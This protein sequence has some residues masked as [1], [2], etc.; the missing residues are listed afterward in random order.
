MKYVYSNATSSG[1]PLGGIGAGSVE[2]RADGLLHDWLIF[3]NGVW[4]TV[5]NRRK[6]YPLDEKSFLLAIRV[7]D[8]REVYVRQLQS[9]GYILG[10]D[11]YKAPWLKPVKLI[12]FYGEPPLARLRYIDDLPV[13]VE[14]EFFS[15]FI[16]GDLKD[17]SMPAVIVKLRVRNKSDRALDV[18]LLALLRSP[19]GKSAIRFKDGILVIEGRG[20][21]IDSPLRDGSMALAVISENV[22]ATAVRAPGY[23]ERGFQ[24]YDNAVEILR[25]WID[26][27]STGA[28]RGPP[29]REGDHLWATASTLFKLAPGGNR[30]TFFVLT[31]FFPNHVDQFGDRL[32]H[33]YEN[34]FNDAEAVAKYVVKNLGRL[35]SET[36]KLHDALYDVK[37][38]ETWVADLV[39]SQLANLVKISWLT[40]DGRFALWEG[41]GDKYYGGPERNAFNTTDVITYAM[42][43]LVSLFPELAAKYLIQHA[44]FSLRRGTPEWVLYAIS[45]PENRREFEK[46][47]ARDPSLA[48]DWQKLLATV[49][50]IVE[51]TGKDPAGRIA[52]YLD[53][54]IKGVDGYH[55]VDL[56]PKYVLMAYITAKW[57]GNLNLLQNLWDVVEGAVESVAKS[58]SVEGLPYHTT[59]SGFEWYRAVRLLF[60]GSAT[61][62]A[63]AA[64]H[65][66]GQNVLPIGFQTFDTWAF[67]GV[68]SYVLALWAAA[69]RAAIDGA[70]RLGK[71]ADRYIELLKRAEEGL[72]VLW[73]G[74]YF[75]LWWDPVTNERDRAS[76]AAQLFGQLLAH[77]ADLGYI[78]DRER[79][80]SS[81]KAVVKYNLA[82]D[83]G[84]INGVY[85]GGDRPSFAGPLTYRNFTKG[86]YL[87]TWQMDTPWSGVEFAV[88][89]HMFYEGLLEEGLAVLKAVH[90]RYERAGHYWNHVEWGAHYMRPLSAWTVV[91]GALGLKYDGFEKELTLRPVVEPL[92]W[93][94]AAAG[95]WGVL[96]WSGDRASLKLEGGMLEIAALRLPKRPTRVALNGQPVPFELI[97]LDGGYKVKL[98]GPVRLEPGG[99]LEIA[100]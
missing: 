41:L 90:E 4:S 44:A 69:L 78:V 72:G 86:P 54:S 61:Q 40:K 8:G 15:P 1:V 93:I 74:E 16:P 20:E 34:F 11:P 77:I 29:A 73:N 76:M 50:K 31:W 87:P 2:I 17:S 57:T 75:D 46:E 47:L 51:K 92:R 81:L 3:N 98:G 88:A 84:L 32:G 58:Q 10:G 12:E 85:P 22:S 6:F 66:L 14:A 95:S 48:L 25:A 39:A 56:M 35:Y 55:M 97:E 23:E 18:S 65:L 53:K 70:R 64:L 37:G 63:N 13:E 94:F 96:D 42:P 82:P 79:V 24:V 9:A 80:V 83:E 19:F 52:H 30:E 5:E 45:I 99:T 67:Y 59:L 91:L 36:K 27:R 62:A 49:V 21:A 68:S 33:Y 71:N 43:A 89:G 28:I 100:F 7:S 38:L 26:F 60:E